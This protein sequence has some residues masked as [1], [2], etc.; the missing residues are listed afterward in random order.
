MTG[1]D[2]THG[3]YRELVS[4]FLHELRFAIRSLS[5]AKG[6]TATVVLTLA[7]GIG[8]N[9]AIFTLVRGVLLRP[10]VNRGEDRLIYIQQSARGMGAEEVAFSVP[11]IQDLRAGVKSLSAFGEFSTIDFTMVGLGDPREVRSGVVDGSFFEVMGLRPVLGRLLDKHDDGPNAAGACVLTH[12]FW[13]TQTKSDRNVLGKTIR[14]GERTATIVGVLEPAVPYPAETEI[15]AN[16]VTSP[17]HL[18]AT[19]VTG[20]V[21]RMTELF[22]RLAPGAT[23][24][25]ARA[26]LRAVYG[27]MIKQHSEAYSPK[28]N[29][30][31]DARLL[32]DQ[33]TSPARNV[34]LILLGASVLMFVIACSNVAN[35]ILARTVRREGE[36][37]T[38][39]ALGAT[40]GALRRTL[41]AES[42]VLC[43]AGAALGVISA[44][45]MLAVLARYA[46]RFS[47]R[48]LDLTVDASMLWVGALLALV[49]AV[50]LAMVPRLP[51][52]DSSRGFGPASGGVRITGSAN[53]RLRA[54][55]VTQIA[56]S[57]VLLAGAAMLTKT[58]ISLQS[59]RTGFDTERVLT[60]SVPVMSYGKTPEQVLSFYKETIRQITSL[61]SV[62]GVA[63]GTFMPWRD[64]GKF[65]PGFSFTA[66]GRVPAP[67]E[68]D[69]RARFRTIS[70]GYFTSLGV[71][72]IAGRD[73]NE[74]DRKDG[75]KVVIVSQSLAQRLF[76]N[77]EAVNHHMTW[78]DPVMKFVGISTEAR[79]IIGVTADV[80]DENVVA[81]PAMTVYHPFSQEDL[82]AANLFIHT[83]GNPYSLIT[84]VTRIIREK[85]SEQPVER[86]AT[87]E[88]IRTEVLSPDRLN[89]LVFGGFAAVALAIAVVGVGG[90]LAFS[91]SGRTREFGIRLAIG[92]QPRH[93]V[94]G[95]LSQGAVI[96]GVGI[97]AGVVGGYALASAAGSVL[98]GMKMPGFVPVAGSAAVLVAAA[99]V[100]SL[101][102][103]A[104][105]ARVD[106]MQALRSE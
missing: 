12:R 69:P 23:L 8:A 56:A 26:E 49:A 64:G 22:G 100:A 9:A 82:W 71:P 13:T 28:A 6:L 41:L 97:A 94:F 102:P 18:S 30:Q 15:I 33:I 48:A 89:T 53:R 35:L 1:H 38:R 42:L 29:F 76:P 4:S 67:G 7:L 59:A 70:P 32:R 79:R 60:V 16:V 83:R 80:D 39:A 104:R 65:G 101:A 92:S 2:E 77:Q 37:C 66:E 62:D 86:A 21:H 61:P 14:L 98:P 5:R 68:E 95:V 58:L 96:A 81:G 57:F 24:E 84:P 73:F 50:A 106:I 105:A 34:L 85:S 43:G 91:V 20:R 74:A 72:L 99:L 52:A 90:V 31:V 27:S 36:L 93:L 44:G 55:A 87:L 51:S 19:M 3:R 17:H 46:S 25:S 11:E 63:V 54:F 10:L 78:T 103:A 45:P 88:D 75:E 47:V 40:T